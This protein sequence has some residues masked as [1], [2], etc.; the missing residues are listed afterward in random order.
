[1]VDLRTSV[2]RS[3][4][5][6]FAQSVVRLQRELRDGAPVDTGATRASTTVKETKRGPLVW[7]AVAQATT[8]AADY[9]NRPRGTGG[10][11]RIFGNP[12]L[13][14]RV[15]GRLVFARSVAVSYQHEG[16]F[17][18][19]VERWPQMVQDAL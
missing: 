14:F 16:W 7:E 1:M 13:A 9:T 8:D 17:D 19:P 12:T 18:D 5:R 4:D 15:N 10:G 6:A 2:Y 11:D 3:L